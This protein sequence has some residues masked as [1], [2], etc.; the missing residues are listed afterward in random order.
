MA[1]IRVQMI[2][3]RNYTHGS[4]RFSRF[5]DDGIT[6]MIYEVKQ[7]LAHDLLA[8][9]TPRGL[10][11]FRL[12]EGQQAPEVVSRP[13]PRRTAVVVRE[14]GSR[15]NMLE[16]D[17]ERTFAGDDDVVY[18]DDDEVDEYDEP[19]DDEDDGEEDPAPVV[20]TKKK[21]T[22]KKRI[23][24]KKIGRPKRMTDSSEGDDETADE[25]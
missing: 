10:P 18:E 12:A 1:G 8:Y 20:V 2:S 21:V 16:G 3:G 25:V 6:P 9:T 22:K 5:A 7:R 11:I 15:Q 14:D 24:K 19:D 13:Q 17:N 4:R 23:V